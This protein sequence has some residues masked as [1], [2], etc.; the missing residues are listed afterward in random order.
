M[1]R[2]ISAGNQI[3]LK[4]VKVWCPTLSKITWN[5]VKK[6]FTKEF[7]AEHCAIKDANVAL[8]QLNKHKNIYSNTNTLFLFYF[9]GGTAKERCVKSQT[10]KSTV[11]MNVSTKRSGW[12]DKGLPHALKKQASSQKNSLLINR[13]IETL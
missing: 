6:S 10:N 12:A 2:W 11:A 8:D 13:K 5:D 4:C 3:S 7:L 9:S 1:C